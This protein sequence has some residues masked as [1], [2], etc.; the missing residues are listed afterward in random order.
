MHSDVCDSVI[1]VINSKNSEVMLL[2]S[3]NKRGG[4]EYQT[5]KQLKFN[6]KLYSDLKSRI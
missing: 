3:E 6:S 4:V 1:I 5:I 2:F